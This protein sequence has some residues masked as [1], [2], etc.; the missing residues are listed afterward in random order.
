MLHDG[1]ARAPKRCR[2]RKIVRKQRAVEN[3]VGLTSHFLQ[4]AMLIARPINLPRLQ[5]YEFTTVA[6]INGVQQIKL[7]LYFQIILP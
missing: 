6:A 4:L 7:Y 3:A 1:A 5:S 2:S